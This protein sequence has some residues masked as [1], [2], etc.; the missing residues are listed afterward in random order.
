VS[1]LVSALFADTFGGKKCWATTISPPPIDE[2]SVDEV[3]V[4]DAI[5]RRIRLR[6]LR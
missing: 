6:P 3:S 2:V 5:C 1:P 4:F